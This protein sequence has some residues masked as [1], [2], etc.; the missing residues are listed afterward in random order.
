GSEEIGP[1]TNPAAGDGRT[2]S[3]T[4]PPFRVRRHPPFRPLREPTHSDTCGLRRR[5]QTNL[6]APSSGRQTL[7]A[8]RPSAARL[9][10]DKGT[11]MPFA[12]PSRIQ[13][14]GE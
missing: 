14:T 5:R 7:S 12:T 9:S 6:A 1:L 4:A 11:S 10:Y 13:R 3:G 2:V 8:D